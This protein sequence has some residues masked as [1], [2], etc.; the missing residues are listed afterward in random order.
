M[1]QIET[2]ENGN[3]GKIT[4]QEFARLVRDMRHNQRRYF[5]TRKWDVLERSKELERKVD[6]VV[7]KVLDDTPELF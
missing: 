3:S 2:P 7:E 4:L 5:A 1:G 6:E